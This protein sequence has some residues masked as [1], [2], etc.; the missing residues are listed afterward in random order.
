[1]IYC[2]RTCGCPKNT[3]NQSKTPYIKTSADKNVSFRKGKKKRPSKHN[4]R[5]R[6][7]VNMNENDKGRKL[8]Y[9]L[10]SEPHVWGY[11]GW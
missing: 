11:G 10:D 2:Y 1:M 4:E 7:H 3:S 5:V 9:L 6:N 8:A